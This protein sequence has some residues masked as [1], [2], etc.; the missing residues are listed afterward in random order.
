M[1][2]ERGISIMETITVIGVMAIILMIV[3]QIF[4]A[5]YDV[6][7][8]QAARVDNETGAILAARAIGD[9][10]QGAD[11]V[12]ASAT[13]N[14]ATYASSVNAL[15]LKIPSIDAAGN[16]VAGSF[17]D[18]AIY[19]DAATPTKIFTDTAPAA[20]SRRPSG[21]HLV[22]AYNQTLAFRYNDPDV[23]LATRVQVFIVNQQ[24]KRSTTLTTN[25]WT[26]FF[27]RNANP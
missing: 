7:I 20:G 5:S 15:V 16:V 13:I 9:A 18:V 21:K 17:D 12:L 3:T 19:R 11:A 4:A 26:A 1:R 25:A 10:A 8:K 2:D 22:T 6:F 24:T 27:L 23:A 14:G